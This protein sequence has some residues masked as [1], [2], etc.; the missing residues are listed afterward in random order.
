MLVMKEYY[1]SKKNQEIWKMNQRWILIL[2]FKE[3]HENSEPAEQYWELG[4]VRGK[5]GLFPNEPPHMP[6]YSAIP[7]VNSLLFLLSPKLQVY[8]VWIQYF[9]WT[10]ELLSEAHACS[11]K[12]FLHISC[13]FSV[14]LLHCLSCLSIVFIPPCP[15]L[16][17]LPISQGWQIPETIVKRIQMKFRN[18]FLCTQLLPALPLLHCSWCEF[19]QVRI[20]FCFSFQ[21][22]IMGSERAWNNVIFIF[23]LTIICL[24]NFR[25]LVIFLYFLQVKCIC[26]RTRENHYWERRWGVS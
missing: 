23:I 2:T 22:V 8:C 14:I 24:S 20:R 12:C 7:N 5:R 4:L 19:Y 18:W 21:G 11:N 16:Q 13:V 1:I 17:G 25:Q 10:R 6:P 15:C 9:M 26:V 3:Q